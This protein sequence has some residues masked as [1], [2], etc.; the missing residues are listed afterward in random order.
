MPQDTPQYVHKEVTAGVSRVLTCCYYPFATAA[1][2]LDFKAPAAQRILGTEP[3][4]GARGLG[5]QGSAWG[6]ISVAWP[7]TLAF[8]PSL[9]ESAVER[10]G[11]LENGRRIRQVCNRS[12]AF[13]LLTKTYR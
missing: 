7:D 12:V 4:D 1:A 11:K 13:A 6:C 8:H 10:G 5:R 3:A 2:D 9:P